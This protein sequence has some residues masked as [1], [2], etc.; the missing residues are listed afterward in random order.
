MATVDRARF[1][2]WVDLNEM[3]HVGVDSGALWRELEVLQSA[4]RSIDLLGLNIPKVGDTVKVLSFGQ[5]MVGQVC[6]VYSDGSFSVRGSFYGSVSV[7]TVNDLVPA[8]PDDSAV[9]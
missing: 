8:E 6:H 4:E 2:H 9:Q 7:F 3:E 1:A 5:I